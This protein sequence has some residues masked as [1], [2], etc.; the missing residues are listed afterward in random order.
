M[1]FTNESWIFKIYQFCMDLILVEFSPTLITEYLFSHNLFLR[2]SYLGVDF[3]S[4]SQLDY[5]DMARDD[6]TNSVE[7][8]TVMELDDSVQQCLEQ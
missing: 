3:S 7:S 5:V 1:K 6:G 2:D 8:S 4:L